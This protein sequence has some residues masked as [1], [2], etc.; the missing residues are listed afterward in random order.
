MLEC[1]GDAVVGLAYSCGAK[2][3]YKTFHIKI[4]TSLRSS[5]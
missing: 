5:G 2:Y 3:D 1:E 4:L